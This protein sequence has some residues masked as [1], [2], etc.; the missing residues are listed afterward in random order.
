MNPFARNTVIICHENA[1]AT[2]VNG[3]IVPVFWWNDNY[4]PLS[5]VV[6]L[7]LLARDARSCTRITRVDTTPF[8]PGG[9]VTVVNPGH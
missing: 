5:G 7:N 1:I 2:R 9:V 4:W 6:A 3:Q 8:R